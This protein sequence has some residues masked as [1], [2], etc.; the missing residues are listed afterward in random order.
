MN[1]KADII[2]RWLFTCCVRR[3]LLL[4]ASNYQT[5]H[6]SL[7]IVIIFGCLP[8]PSLHTKRACMFIELPV[9]V[10]TDLMHTDLNSLLGGVFVWY[11]YLLSIIHNILSVFI[12]MCLL[13]DYCI[14]LRL[15]WATRPC[16]SCQKKKT[17]LLQGTLHHYLLRFNTKIQTVTGTNFLLFTRRLREKEHKTMSK[18]RCTWD[19]I[20]G[21]LRFFHSAWSLWKTSI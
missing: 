6:P 8:P 12:G 5:V 1:I 7:S 11:Q 16:S 21:S 2:T 9:L 13:K 20:W 19:T 4:P 15:W 10:Y 3:G 14:K 17:D 18:L